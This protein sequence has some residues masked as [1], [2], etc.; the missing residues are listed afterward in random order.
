M[1]TPYQDHQEMRHKM[2]R[3]SPNGVDSI[4]ECTTCL[5]AWI[6]KPDSEYPIELRNWL[7]RIYV[8][9]QLDYPSDGDRCEIYQTEDKQLAFNYARHVLRGNVWC[10][11]SRAVHV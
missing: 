7:K 10:V 11:I 9:I 3:Y 2:S 1:T 5:R 6:R 8:V 4:E